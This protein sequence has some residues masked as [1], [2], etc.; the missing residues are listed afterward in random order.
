M[1]V[2]QQRRSCVVNSIS[3]MQKQRLVLDCR[4]RA[5]CSGGFDFRTGGGVFGL[6]IERNGESGNVTLWC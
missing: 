2:V 3:E 1:K 5:L 6:K 4:S